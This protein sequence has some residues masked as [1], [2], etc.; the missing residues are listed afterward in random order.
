MKQ[1][2]LTYQEYRKIFEEFINNNQLLMSL[3]HENTIEIKENV[4]WK[5]CYDPEDRTRKQLPQ[6][7]FVSEDGDLGGVQCNGEKVYM[8][9][10][11]WSTGYKKYHMPAFKTDGTGTTKVI[12][13][14]NLVGLVF[15]SYRYGSADRMIEENGLRAF[16][17]KKQGV[18]GVNGHHIDADRLNNQP[19]NAEFVS[20]DMHILIDRFPKAGSSEEKRLRYLKE[21]GEQ[22]SKEEPDQITVLLSGQRYDR[23]G[24]FIE[25]TGEQW[26]YSTD[27]LKTTKYAAEAINDLAIKGAC[28]LLVEKVVGQLCQEHGEEYFD[29]SRYCSVYAIY[30]YKCIR[31][32]EGS[33]EI[34]EMKP[35][36]ITPEMK[37]LDCFVDDDGY[38]SVYIED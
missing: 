28:R 2:R 35:K 10:P 14:L 6:H 11:D 19:D 23:N 12:A 38:P 13:A 9:Q 15:G 30:F 34:I 3:N 20:T 4:K 36:D 5:Q 16:S 17:V 26:I 31:N 37:I 33:L 29:E 25:D 22:A 7:W 8:I 32:D 21:F 18:E 24:E 27:S 1:K